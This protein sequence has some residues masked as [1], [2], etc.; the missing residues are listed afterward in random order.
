MLLEPPV[1]F[2]LKRM[3]K[4][5]VES[6]RLRYGLHIRLLAEN[7]ASEGGAIDF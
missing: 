2:A 5:G 7:N 4:L 6:G 3:F 1:G